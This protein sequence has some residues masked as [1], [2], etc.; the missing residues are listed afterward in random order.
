[1]APSLTLGAAVVDGAV[2]AAAG[3][4]A[5]LVVAGADSAEAL[6]VAAASVVAARAVVGSKTEILVSLVPGPWISVSIRSTR[7][8]HG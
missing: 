8:R 5:V 2:P 3:A 4:E 7:E 1:L 6:V